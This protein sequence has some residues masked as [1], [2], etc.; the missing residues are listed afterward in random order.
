VRLHRTDQAGTSGYSIPSIFKP[1]VPPDVVD[2]ARQAKENFDS[3]KYRSV[4]KLY[5]E[6]L[7]KTPNNLYSLSN[8]GVLYFRTGKLKAAE[9]TLKKA[10]AIAPKDEFATPPSGSFI[11]GNRNTTRRSLS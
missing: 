6:I 5:Q 2:L 1:N 3:G 11:I 8:L 9:L 7:T 10:V 4:K